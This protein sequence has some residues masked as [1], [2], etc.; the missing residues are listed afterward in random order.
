MW[1]PRFTT[2]CEPDHG[3][4]RCLSP[5]RLARLEPFLAQYRLVR[6]RDGYRTD[7]ADYYRALP[8]TAPD[9]PQR[10]IWRIRQRS[11]RRLWRR[12]LTRRRRYAPAVLDLG[13]GNGWL[14]AQLAAA[15]CR[16]VAVDL[17][18]D[19]RDGLGAC[20]HY[21]TPF[22]CVQADFDA[23]PF[24]PGQ[25]DVVIF[26]ASLHYAPDAATTLQRTAAL[27][28]PGGA[29]VVSDSPTFAHEPDG[30]S[31]RARNRARFTAEYGVVSPIEPGEGYLT[32]ERLSESAGALGLS[33]RY[34][35]SNGGLRQRVARARAVWNGEHQPPRFGVWVAT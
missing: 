16:P 9:D 29:L 14:S 18:D 7:R 4:F 1:L 6:E 21:D 17:L 13:A 35:T 8:A 3:V 12:V 10:P 34:F 26:N 25:F 23:L 24:A 22:A 31:M 30:W 33:P 11:F 32:F 27:L 20:R 28:A 5:E 2:P 15:G 19:D